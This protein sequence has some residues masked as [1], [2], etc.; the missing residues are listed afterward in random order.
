M[1]TM[2]PPPMPPAPARAPSAWPTVIGIIG[3]VFG[4]LAAIG[5]CFGAGMT[6]LLEPLLTSLQGAMP[7]DQQVTGTEGL[8][9]YTPWLVGASL[10][11]SAVAIVLLVGGV[12]LTRRRSAAVK[13]LVTWAV[14]K[15]LYALPYNW[16]SYK[17]NVANLEQMQNDPNMSGVAVGGSSRRSARSAS[18]SAC[19]GRGPCRCS[20]SS[21]SCGARYAR[22]SRAGT[23][24]AARGDRR[25]R[26]TSGPSLRRLGPWTSST[27]SR[28]AGCSTRR[29]PRTRS[30]SASG[31]PARSRTAVSIRPP[32]A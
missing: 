1:S 14:L 2:P 4:S 25:R 30:G 11:G 26:W 19:S 10:A 13:V 16:I 31:R 23:S 22:R 9:Q 5:G 20:C 21:G 7:E 28:G 15:M 24:L 8:L 12:M 27:S 18:S 6:L 32:T 17:V 29:P 3:I